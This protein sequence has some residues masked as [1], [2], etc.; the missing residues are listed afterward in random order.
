MLNKA[1]STVVSQS[2]ISRM[3]W[4]FECQPC[5]VEDAIHEAYLSLLEEHFANITAAK[6]AL[7]G[8]T[9]GRLINQFRHNETISEKADSLKD[10]LLDISFLSWY[11]WDTTSL[12]D[13]ESKVLGYILE[14]TR[15]ADIAKIF[16][17]S[18]AAISKMMKKIGVKCKVEE[19]T[20][21]TGSMTLTEDMIINKID[22]D[23]VQ[24]T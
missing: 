23:L 22:M 3:S 16:S 10:Y 18:K 15:P 21:K 13:N 9:K 8:R 12:T 19:V 17:V 6:I 20:I 14:G 7:M 5:D 24:A 11:D 4:R 1:Y 2:Y